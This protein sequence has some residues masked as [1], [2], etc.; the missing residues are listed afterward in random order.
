[1]LGAAGVQVGSA[2]LHCPESK[3][4]APHRAALAAAQDDLATLC[5]LSMRIA[6]ALEAACGPSRE[7]LGLDDWIPPG[8]I[9][10]ELARINEKSGEAGATAPAQ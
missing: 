6:L 3:V 5:K 9:R 2:Y 10:R 4:T 7:A 1:M 8:E